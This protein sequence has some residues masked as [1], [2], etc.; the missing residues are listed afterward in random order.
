MRRSFSSDDELYWDIF[1]EYVQSMVRSYHIGLEFF[2]EGTRSRT[3]KAICPK[4]GLLSMA[5]EP[6]IMG[7]VGDVTIVPVSV[8]YEKVLEEE[9]FVYEML[10]VP[11]PKES[12][13]GLFKAFKVVQK[14][15]GKMYMDLGEPISARE[16][17]ADKNID[18]VSRASVAAHVQKLNKVEIQAVKDLANEI[19]VKQ[20]KGIVI[21]TFNLIAVYYSYSQYVGNEVKLAYL[22]EG[23]FTFISFLKISSKT[24]SIPGVGI[25]KSLFESL[26]AN[27]ATNG[28]S[29]Q[30]DIMDALE[31]HPNILKLIKGTVE[32]VSNGIDF[33][34]IDPKRLKGFPLSK[35]TM[36][37]A[38]PI[39]S[40]QIYINPCLFWL[41][42]LSYT[43]LGA[44]RLVEEASA[45][46]R[47]VLQATSNELSAIFSS[48]FILEDN[49]HKT[50]EILTELGVFEKFEEFYIFKSN[51]ISKVILSS[52]APF[53]AIYLQLADTILEEVSLWS[54][55]LSL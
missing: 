50:F 14:N 54:H 10:G 45:I 1:R 39:M 30:Y 43:I 22:C 46:S 28:K 52:F 44:L 32:L 11:K 38:V 6:F 47:E 21:T 3:F 4:I 33:Q 12:T 48:E 18:R 51:H 37:T 13:T 2:V 55:I 20:Q 29:I 15:F 19:V 5:L 27:V 24:I 49:F 36:Q 34:P 7:E 41:S 8:S 42:N 40:L 35:E 16:Y 9:L 25:L 31:V 26:G 17:F 53:M 23:E